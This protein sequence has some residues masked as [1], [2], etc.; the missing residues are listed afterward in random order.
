MTSSNPETSR[1]VNEKLFNNGDEGTTAKNSTEVQAAWTPEEVQPVAKGEAWEEKV[2]VESLWTT[3]ASGSVRLRINEACRE[4]T[5]TEPLT[6]H[7]MFKTSV[8]RYGHLNALAYKK[9]NQWEKITFPEYYHCCRRAGKSFL[10]LEL[11]RFHGVGILG[12]NSP[13]WFFSA[14]GGIMAGG[15]LTGIYSTNCPEACHYVAS[16]SKAN[17]IMVENQKQLEKILQIR[18]RLPDLKAIVQYSGSPQQKLPNLYS[19]EEFLELG[20]DVSDSELDEMMDSQRANQCCTLIYTSGT[21]GRPKGVM[22]SH[23]NITWTA[24]HASRAGDVSAGDV[25]QETLVSYLPLSHIAAQMFDIWT[26]IQWGEMVYFAQPD[27]LKG[28]LV[29]TLTEVNPSNHM[30]VPRVWE[31]IMEKVKEEISRCGYVK[32]KLVTWAMSVSLQHHQRPGEKQFLFAL[33]DSL[34]LEKLRAQLGFSHCHKFFSGAAPI[35][36]ETIEFFLGLNICLYEVYGMSE[37]TGPHFVSGPRAYKLPSCGKVIP[38]CRA[39]LS[40]MDSSNVGEVCCWGRNIFMG[41]LNMEDK[42]LEALD[43]E[44]WLRSGDLGRI[45]QDGFLYIT[46]RIKE[47]IITAGGE[48]IPPVPIEEAV[49]KE[50]PLISNAMLIGDKRKFLSLLL[51][52]KVTVNTETTEPT[53][54]LSLEAV[55]FCQHLGSQSTKVSDIIEGQDQEVYLAIQ[56][57]ID[58]VNA[59]ATSNAQII[60]KWTILPWDFSIAGGELGPTLKLH[61]PVVLNMYHKEIENFYK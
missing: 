13:E 51:T 40:N 25:Q 17:I 24:I 22:L 26:A 5:T 10:K 37:S 57:G 3:K 39:K 48:N 46:G 1:N 43:E 42:T 6:V 54:E 9:N 29:T 4:E 49:K 59:Q 34:V 19:W 56:Q 31:K 14:I 8:K 45:D 21:T 16:D 28:S 36:M 20:V 23:D 58:R 18:S 52:L 61:R 12:S 50:L 55:Q 47:L 35:G 32:K 7:Q 44:G 27:A 11:K 2:A 38:G 33:A 30:G 60:Q 53:Q 15:I 41:F